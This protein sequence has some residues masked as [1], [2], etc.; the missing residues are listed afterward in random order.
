MRFT[1]FFF[2]LYIFI[3]FSCKEQKLQLNKIE[4]SQI[5]ITDSLS[6]DAEIETFIKPFKEHI[7]KD[8]D[9]TLAYAVDTYSKS[10][11]HLNTAIGN[12]MAD[13][14]YDEANPIFKSRTGNNIDMVLLNYGGIR[15]IIS[16]GNVSTR[17]AFEIMPFENSIVVV[18]LKGTQIDS[19]V[20]YLTTRKTAHPISK[21]KLVVDKD[22]NVVEATI[23]GEKINANKTYY[24]ATNDYLYNNGDNMRFFRPNEGTNIL[25]YKVRNALIDYFKKV[26]T[27]SPVI[28]N[29]FIQIN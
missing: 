5:Q 6:A 26:D 14:I 12:F 29:R 22:F 7:Q 13:A 24:V 10:D 16:K 28:D 27:I 8:L 23:K 4:G 3:F 9:S 20:T 25:N 18:A 2:L 21:M 15:S 1:H 19:M 17:T 11:G